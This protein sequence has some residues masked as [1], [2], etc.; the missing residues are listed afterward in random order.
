MCYIL[1][2]IK[3]GSLNFDFKY[4]VHTQ[5]GFRKAPCILNKVNNCETLMKDVKAT[6]LC[7][8]KLILIRKH[9]VKN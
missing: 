8:G 7:V 5:P 6:T 2:C 3:R 9:K 1:L 4:T